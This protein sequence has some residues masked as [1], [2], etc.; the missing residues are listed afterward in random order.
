MRK[1]RLTTALVTIGALLALAPLPGAATGANTSTRYLVVL[2]GSESA[3]GFDLAGTR[4][5]ALGPWR[6]RAAR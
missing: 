3:G 5:A 6:S 4:A 1:L 2:A